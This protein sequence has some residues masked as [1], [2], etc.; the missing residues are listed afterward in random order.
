MKNEGQS[1]EVTGCLSSSLGFW[2]ICREGM[3]RDIDLGQDAAILSWLSFRGGGVGLLLSQCSWYGRVFR[4]GLRKGGLALAL[5]G[6]S[7][8]RARL[9]FHPQR[10]QKKKAIQLNVSE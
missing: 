1:P 9:L 7:S 4:A 3:K 6:G 2:M 8:S 10:L 5:N